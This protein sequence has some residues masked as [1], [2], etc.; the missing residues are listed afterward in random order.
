MRPGDEANYHARAK[1]RRASHVK[2]AKNDVNIKIDLC[3]NIDPE[4]RTTLGPGNQ[5]SGLRSRSALHSRKTSLDT[6][7]PESVGAPNGMS[8]VLPVFSPL[9]L[10]N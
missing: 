2:R 9:Q 7:K 10:A 3:L 8:F 6:S 5:R 1:R 4:L